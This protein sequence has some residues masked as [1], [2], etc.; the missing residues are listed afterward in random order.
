MLHLGADF[1]S[2]R[3]GLACIA[4][5]V[6]G[7]G[8]EPTGVI[9]GDAGTEPVFDHDVSILIAGVGRCLGSPQDPNTSMTI[10]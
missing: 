4:A 7:A 2:I 10:I 9:G 1:R 3:L 8:Q 6:T 5:A